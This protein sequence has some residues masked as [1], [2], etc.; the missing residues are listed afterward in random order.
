MGGELDPTLS[1][2]WKDKL[3]GG[4]IGETDP[5]STVP[6]EG[7]DNDLELLEGDVNTTTIDG[8]QAITFSDRLKNLL[9]REMEFTIIVKLLGR[10]IGYNALHNCILSLWKLVNSSRIMDTI[11]GYFLLNFRLLKITTE[12]CHKCGAAWIRLLN[13]PGHLYKREII[14]AIGSLIGKVVKLD[15]QTD[16]QTRGRFARLAVYINLEKPLISQVLVDGA[17]KRIEY[18]TFLTVCFT[19]GKYSHVKDMCPMAETDPNFMVASGKPSTKVDVSNEGKSDDDS[20]SSRSKEK[21]LKF[22]PWVLVEKRHSRRGRRDF[23]AEVKDKQRQ[24]PLGSRFTALMGDGNFY[25][26]RRAST[27][28]FSRENKKEAARLNSL[29]AREGLGSEN[30]DGMGRMPKENLEKSLGKRPMGSDGLDNIS[31]D[32]SAKLAILNHSL[33]TLTVSNFVNSHNNNLLDAV[34]GHENLM[35]KNQNNMDIEYLEKIKAHY[36]PVFDESEGFIVPIS[37]NTLDPDSRPMEPTDLA[38]GTILNGS[39]DRK[40]GGSRSNCKPFFALRGRR[41]R[42]KT[43]GNMRI[44]LTESIKA[45]AE[46]I[47]PQ[48]LSK[49]LRVEMD[50]GCA[51]VK[52]SR[53]F[54]EYNMDCKPDIVSLLEPRVSGV[55]DSSFHIGWRRLMP[56]PYL[57]FISFVYGSPNRQ[58]R[59]LLWNDLKNAIISGQIPWMAIGDF[60]AILASS[61][62]FGGLT[63]GRRCSQGSLSERLDRALGSEA[64]NKQVY[65]NITTR[66]K[67]LIKRIANIQ[68]LND[69]SGSHHLNEVDLSLRREL[70]NLLHHEELLWRQ[71]ARCDWLKL[72]DRNTKFF[73]SRT[74]QRRKGNRIYAIQ[75]FDGTWIYDLKGIKG[76]A[77]EFF[78]RL[79][80]E[81][82][83]PLGVLPPNRFPQLDLVDI[84]FL[85]NQSQ[86]KKLRMIFDG[87]S[88]EPDMNN[89][90]I[91][92]IPEVQ[93]LKTFGK[94]RPISLCSVLYKLT[95]KVIANRFKHIFPKIITQ[96]QA[97]FIVG[98]NI[99]ENIILA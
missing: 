46:L 69:Q 90:L 24:Q 89:T 29:K 12:F 80:S 51:N 60:N 67:G 81:A 59:Q 47:S 37:D 66:K 1:L 45:M 56:S 43:S 65:G 95:M 79:Y 38:S 98:R 27:G 34:G 10:N 42:F 96:E 88:I 97:G 68:R 70:E 78:Q 26:V 40:C 7:N 73:H 93:N 62:K 16:N 9:F 58:I 82:P 15:V 54:R 35:S 50:K 41:S 5:D 57:I 25:G 75:N 32:Y 92:L 23:S 84:N 30:L 21:E 14:V 86:M 19:C 91:I 44:P 99:N 39:K 11:I 76:E 53:I 63:K 28:G 48:I 22:G 71:K 8:V 55:K 77:N 6:A 20:I 74:L 49:N 33:P 36:N 87:N 3:L 94:F 72:G 85:G 83:T 52:F 18:L 13:L 31:R 4:S 64:W 2:S 61:E 17:I